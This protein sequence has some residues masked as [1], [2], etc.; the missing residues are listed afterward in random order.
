M[1]W[2][3]IYKPSAHNELAD[4]WLNAADRQAI[5]DAADEIDGLLQNSPIEASESRSGVT[6]IIIR[7]P[8]TVLFDLNE[9]DALITVLAMNR[10]RR[11]K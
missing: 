7:R 6:R 11:T 2:T 3:V 1:K 5:A 10:W 8:L 4:I 9:D